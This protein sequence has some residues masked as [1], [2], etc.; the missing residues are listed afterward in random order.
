MSKHA[1]RKLTLAAA[2]TM[3]A[4]T[5]AHAQT[6]TTPPPSPPP[7]PDTVTGTDPEPTSPQVIGTI[8]HLA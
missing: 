2:I 4:V 8:L 6:S 1:F 7:T 3:L 5:R